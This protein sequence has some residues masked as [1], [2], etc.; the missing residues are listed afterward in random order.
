[1]KIMKIK[2]RITETWGMPDSTF[3]NLE[4][5]FIFLQIVSYCLGNI[6]SNLIYY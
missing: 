5:D 3:L 2:G 4:Y 6:R 1:M